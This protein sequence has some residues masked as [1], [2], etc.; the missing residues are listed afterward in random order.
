MPIEVIKD[1][2]T[3]DKGPILQED[4]QVLH[5][6]ANVILQFSKEESE[7]V[8]SL[9]VTTKRAVWLK[10]GSD[11]GFALDFH[12]IMCHA[13]ARETSNHIVKPCIYCQLG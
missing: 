10:D 6:Q 3:T 11:T 9:Y 5:S 13:I 2:N 4:E 7:G 12:E 8:G 1:R